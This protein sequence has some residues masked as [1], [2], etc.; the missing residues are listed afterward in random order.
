MSISSFRNISQT[1]LAVRHCHDQALAY[2]KHSSVIISCLAGSLQ[3]FGHVIAFAGSIV[4]V[5]SSHLL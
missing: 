2:G 3:V 1:P 5:R 4:D